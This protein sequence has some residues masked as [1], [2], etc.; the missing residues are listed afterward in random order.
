MRARAYQSR[1]PDPPVGL[2]MTPLPAGHQKHVVMKVLESSV[3]LVKT[4]ILH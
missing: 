4:L 3:L 2:V 1:L